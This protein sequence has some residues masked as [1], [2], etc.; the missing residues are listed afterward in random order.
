MLELLPQGARRKCA[1][2]VQKTR[3]LGPRTGRR[4]ERSQVL[5]VAR[6]RGCNKKKMKNTNPGLAWSLLLLSLLAV[7]PHIKPCSLPKQS[8]VDDLWVHSLVRPFTHQ[9][10]IPSSIRRSQLP[11]GDVRQGD[12]KEKSSRRHSSA[13]APSLQ[14]HNLRRGLLA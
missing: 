4:E 5:L 9:V 8:I 7:L 3:E 1:A 12:E 14:F 2:L 10:Y 6:A 11:S 13:Q